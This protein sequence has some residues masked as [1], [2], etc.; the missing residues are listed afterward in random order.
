MDGIN[1][2]KRKIAKKQNF[3]HKSIDFPLSPKL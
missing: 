2:V 1:A 3:F